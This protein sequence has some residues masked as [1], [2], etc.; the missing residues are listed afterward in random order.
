MTGG[1]LTTIEQEALGWVIRLQHADADD[2]SEFEA[3]LEC[4][5]ERAEIYWRLAAADADVADALAAP[6]PPAKVI[7][8]E[9]APRSRWRM[10][11]LI[12]PLA[13]SVAMVVGG[14]WALRPAPAPHGPQLYAVETLPGEL[15]EIALADGT[16]IALNGATR[17]ELDRASPRSVQ[18]VRGQ[19][20]FDVVHD[21]RAPFVVAAGD[22]TIRDVGTVFDLVRD[23][24]GLRVAVAMGAVLYEE[25]AGSHRLNAGDS[26]VRRAD[27]QVSLARI[28]PADVAAWREHR[29]IYDR[30]PFAMV[31]ADL[32][33]S[34]GVSV[35][36]D[37]AI[38]G[39]RFSGGIRLRPDDADTVARAAAMMGVTAR[40]DG[41]GWRLA[42][43]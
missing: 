26:L 27:G 34:T 31:A 17:I 41:T 15:R 11:S 39:R 9:G 16:K 30:A 28:D 23:P 8:F 14:Y 10:P 42:A 38:G 33:R 40:K 19:A 36:V 5:P 6:L 18:L 2:W 25:K 22:A 21:A 13:A 1:A 3:W 20:R 4:D 35:T 24:S 37:P 7:P 12:L 32:A 29:L 43:P